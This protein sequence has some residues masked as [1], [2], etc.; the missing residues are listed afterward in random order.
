M[1]GRAIVLAGHGSHLSIDSSEPTRAHAR[2][3]RD[4]GRYDDV[5]VAFWKEEP[6]LARVLDGVEADD[7]TVVPVFMS[8]GYFVRQVIPREMRLAGPLTRLDGKL[9]R[10]TRALGDHPSLA[11]VVLQRAIEAG[12]QPDDA[13]ALLGHGTPRDPGSAKNIYQQ[14]EQVGR[15]GFF[16]ETTA[17]FIDQDPNMRD[18][19]SMVRA[20]RVIMV[21]LFVADGWHV[22]ETIPEDMQLDHQ[23]ERPD[24]RSLLYAGA[25]GTHPQVAEV[26]AEMIEE[27]ATWRESSK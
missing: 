27:A 26:I 22:G 16:R 14:C 20:P 10:Y 25:V 8:N 17:V 6:S 11:R 5:R 13:L 4:T 21:P 1:T 9:V 2:R 15:L 23:G 7:V 19:F 18:V 12:A 24:G 3:L